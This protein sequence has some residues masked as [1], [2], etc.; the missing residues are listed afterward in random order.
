MQPRGKTCFLQHTEILVNQKS[1][2]VVQKKPTVKID[3]LKN[4]LKKC[5]LEVRHA[6]CNTQKA[7]LAQKSQK[8]PWKLKHK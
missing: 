1:E 7:L 2:K 6:F 8:V 4:Q 3:V 5:N